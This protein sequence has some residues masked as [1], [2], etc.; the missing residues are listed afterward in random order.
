MKFF[1]EFY[2]RRSKHKFFHPFEELPTVFFQLFADDFP[3]LVPQ[4]VTN[5][6]IASLTVAQAAS[7]RY[8]IV[9]DVFAGGD[10]PAGTFFLYISEFKVV[11]ND[12]NGLFSFTVFA[13]V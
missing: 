11:D 10:R 3:N 2:A 5:H 12:V 1:V 4:F 9:V 6:L 7:N 13:F 8:V